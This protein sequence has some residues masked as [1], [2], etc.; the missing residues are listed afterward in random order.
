MLRRRPRRGVEVVDRR[1]YE[2][3]LRL[4]DSERRALAEMEARCEAAE[5]ALAEERYQYRVGNETEETIDRFYDWARRH[6]KD[7]VDL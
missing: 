1:R 4:V 6:M 7:E 2:Q 3:A 5:A